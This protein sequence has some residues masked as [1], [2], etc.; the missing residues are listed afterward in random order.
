[1]NE[2]TIL[3]NTL[4]LGL[5]V[6]PL[7]LRKPPVK[8]WSLMYVANGVSSDI[9][10]RFLVKSGRLE[11]PV[12]LAPKLFA[13]SVL[14]DYVI[15][16]LISVIYCQT[17]YNTKPGII[18]LLGALFAIPQIVIEYLAERKTKLIKYKNGWTWVHSYLG[19]VAVKLAMRAFIEIIRPKFKQAGIRSQIT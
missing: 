8:M 2:R 16:P 14:Y 6:L 5:A 10:N 3:R 7:L 9:I 17:T 11:Y 1:M 4:F 15:C 18:I 12:R 19:I 13:N